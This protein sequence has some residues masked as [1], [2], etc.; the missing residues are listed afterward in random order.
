ME[1]GCAVRQRTRPLT[2]KTILTRSLGERAL[3]RG[4]THDVAQSI[5]PRHVAPFACLQMRWHLVGREAGVERKEG[6]GGDGPMGGVLHSLLSAREGDGGGDSGGWRAFEV[7]HD[8]EELVDGSEQLGRR[9]D[10]CRAELRRAFHWQRRAC[11]RWRLRRPC[12]LR[13]WRRRQR[14]RRRRHRCGRLHRRG[15]RRRRRWRQRQRQRLRRRWR[16]QRCG[17]EDDDPRRERA[18]AT[19]PLHGIGEGVKAVG[20]GR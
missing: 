15:R 16:R 11:C 4:V 13:R 8:V 3:Q 6:G 18:T 10:G 7:A 12:Q 14:W 1:L 9:L 20:E 2:R 5:P 19:V 17:V